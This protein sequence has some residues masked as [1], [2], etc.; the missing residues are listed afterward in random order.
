MTTCSVPRHDN[1]TSGDSLY[2][3]RAC[4]QAFI[5][6]CWNTHDFDFDSWHHGFGYEDCCNVDLPLARTFN[7]FWLLNYSADDYNNDQYS[8]NMLHWGRR[9]VRD[10]MDDVRAAC[11]DG[12]AA[13]TTFDYWIFGKH[14]EFYLA[15]W[16]QEDVA[17]RAGTLVHESRHFG[18]KGHDANFP[19]GSVFGA[20]RS[21]ADSSWGYQGAW[22]FDALY[23]WWFYADGRRSTPALRNAAKQRANLIIDN[24]F[25]THPGFTIT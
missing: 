15:F 3:P 5:D 17:S 12:S 25:A 20:G 1:A 22:M 21:G 11:G 16:Y 10:Q 6:W 18:G 2:G 4:W 19:A 8:N 7:A 24:A 9:Y 23:L 14:V 13:A